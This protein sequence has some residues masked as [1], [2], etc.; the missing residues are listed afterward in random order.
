[1]RVGWIFLFLLYTLIFPISLSAINFKDIIFTPAKAT[2]V[3]ETEHSQ[4]NQISTQPNYSK[5]EKE[6]LS[7]KINQAISNH[8]KIIV[9][10]KDINQ[11]STK[12][13]PSLLFYRYD[14]SSN[15]FIKVNE[16]DYLSK[17]S[18][19][20]NHLKKLPPLQLPTG[21]EI[22]VGKEIPLAKCLVYKKREPIFLIYD[23]PFAQ[24]S[25]L[26]FYIKSDDDKEVIT[27]KRDGNS[28]NY[29]GYINT[30]TKCKR[31]FDGKLFIKE[32]DELDAS[33]YKPIGK[34]SRSL[35]RNIHAKA[36]IV[37]KAKEVMTLDNN[38]S[39]PPKIWIDMDVSKDKVDIGEFFRVDIE[40]ENSGDSDAVSTKLI[41]RLSFGAKYIK[42]SF[43]LDD[44]SF[45]NF[46]INRE[47][48]SFS[49]KITLKAHQKRRLSFVVRNE[50][51][52][53]RYIIDSSEILYDKSKSNSATIKVKRVG[54]FDDGS[55]ITGKV[56]LEGNRSKGIEGIKLYLDSGR[57][58]LS[59][60]YGKFHFEDID[61]SLHVISIDPSSIKGKYIAY[62]CRSNARSS[63]SSISRFVDASSAHI[64]D[65]NF[66]VR[67]NNI[68]SLV[69]SEMSYKIPKPKKITMAEYTTNSFDTFKKKRGFLW[70]KK[71]FIPSMP[72]VKVA[73]LHKKSDKIELF[74]NGKKADMLNYDGYV[75][76][77][78]KK[79]S[80]SK[81][82]GVD[83]EDGDNILEMVVKD[84]NSKEVGR[85]KRKIHLSTSPT[86]AVVIPK[87]SYLVA[88]GENPPVIAVKMYDASGYPLRRGITGTY[89]ISKPYIS[90]DK[91]KLFEDNPIMR[92]GAKNRFV[93][94]DDGVAYI[95]LM[96]TT[97]TGEVKLHFE[98]QEENNYI[99][100]W[101]KP[102]KQKW[103]IVGFAEGSVGY[104]EIK[105]HLKKG[106]SKE[107]VKD[108]SISLFAKGTIGKD[109]LLTIAYQSNKKRKKRKSFED[110]GEQNSRV[111][112]IYSDS[113]IDQNEA[114]TSKKLYLKIE[115]EQFYALFGDFETGLD[116]HELSK[117]SRR[118][119]GI[120]S[121]YH[122][123]KFEYVAFA[124][125]SAGGFKRE[126]IK[127][128]GT[129]GPYHI[130]T[131]SLLAGS[132]KV[133]IEV[134]DRYKDELVLDKTGYDEVYD[135]SID[136]QNGMIYF[137]EPIPS[138][139][140]Y[141]NPQTI[142]VEYEIDDDKRDRIVIGGRG[143]I[144]L[145]N[146]R[147]EVGATTIA[148]EDE[149][150]KYNTLYGIDFKANLLKNLVLNGE[151]AKSK[152]GETDANAYLL[153]LEQFNR[154][155]H[156]KS[157]F[158]HQEKGFG[159]GFQNNSLS[160]SNRYGIDSSINYFDNFLIKFSYYGENSLE[161]DHKKNTLESKAIFNRG[162]WIAMAGYRYAKE[163]IK[164]END[165][166]QIISSLQKKFFHSKMGV[167]MAYEKSLGK[168]SDYKK[169]RI[170]GEVTYKL[171]NSLDLFASQELLQGAIQRDETSKVGVKGRAWR[172][173]NIESG[174]SQ[175]F[176]NDENRLFGFL[177]LN[178]YYRVDE[179]LSLNG[180]IEKQK[181]LNSQKNTKD[182]TSYSIG[183]NYKHKKWI[184]NTL[185]E[186][187]D[188]F[189]SDK[190]NINFGIYT[191]INRDLGFAMGIRE[192]ITDE[193]NSR[194]GY[195]GEAKFSLAYRG[196]RDYTLLSQLKLKHQKD[197]LN[198]N[199]T[200]IGA[201]KG[202][203]KP[204]SKSQISTH[205][206]IKH[207]TENIDNDKFSSTVDSAGIEVIYDITKRF[208]LGVN[209]SLLHIWQ[210][211]DLKESYGGYL[212][213]SFFKNLYLGVG[214]NFKGYYD[215]DLSEY[216][217]SA[218][219][220]YLKMRMKL[221]NESLGQV[222]KKF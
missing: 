149:N 27:L 49:T 147:V 16:V 10:S 13:Q 215:K 125:N 126:E 18:H 122:S 3:I 83:I 190:I 57:Y 33:P 41:N 70:P 180:S 72:S 2:F 17:N 39:T 220:I 20:K 48:N 138:R 197:K 127:P 40:L 131:N 86:R 174:I 12:P 173:A 166:S 107:M 11:T 60:K 102:K 151:Y 64:G 32:G 59:D 167:Y 179:N 183:A 23:D 120:K 71:D 56:L 196:D 111:F 105:K 162:G 163:N 208:E 209:G 109:T 104:Q 135:Y 188:G 205:Y 53:P 96:P 219:G 217:N 181:T 185:L 110:E 100:T 207:T 69:K 198:D 91:S 36:H 9:K 152:N 134:R 29:I 26:K 123:D 150:D 171:T 191:E 113:A 116:K 95:Q 87:K 6:R 202:V 77:S 63:G 90:L 156:T 78:N 38:T 112:T 178:Q 24:K 94:S 25:N 44:K 211:G 89:E 148:H 216:L 68:T 55:I 21:E 93:I 31:E 195:D 79:W 58:T 73:F 221:D 80:I 155:T 76:S 119:N 175:K 45:T 124:S 34:K 157:Y 144:K 222:A 7:T 74:I 145:A 43:Y 187:K 8:V 42:K 168:R 106:S 35:K 189:E 194:K 176:E 201:V 99:T 1:M 129:S 184:Y 118:L 132:E 5:T 61:P 206:T 121:E 15:F 75:N 37:T 177:G 199:K 98:F 182:Y 30:T 143:A 193:V 128:D 192:N 203:I 153:Q 84:N 140:R 66:C 67:E 136:Y 130:K 218:E 169:D 164:K 81:Y 204:T 51:K 212:G 200:V 103:F 137:K 88:D 210:S 28:T 141:G 92:E 82:R 170:F 214:Y 47:K 158:R 108:G 46:D 22:D 50:A 19:L 117:Y 172:G 54:K 161:D 133:Y 114:P 146:N 159:L 213:Y 154:Y 14:T 65:I 85:F 115:K 165:V 62:E 101:L 186:Y 4:I 139:D 97:M 52:K 142:V 160:G